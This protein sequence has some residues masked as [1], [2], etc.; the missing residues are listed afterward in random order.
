MN[1]IPRTL[2]YHHPDYDY[3]LKMCDGQVWYDVY[4]VETEEYDTLTGTFINGKGDTIEEEYIDALVKLF[5]WL[6]KNGYLQQI[7]DQQ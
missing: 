1:A 2:E 5:D 3:E 7:L 6:F 4:N